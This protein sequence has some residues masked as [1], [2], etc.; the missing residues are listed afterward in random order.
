[1]FFL[2]R[3]TNLAESKQEVR[4]FPLVNGLWQGQAKALQKIAKYFVDEEQFSFRMNISNDLACAVTFFVFLL[5]GG[6]KKVYNLFRI[7]LFFHTLYYFSSSSSFFLYLFFSFFSLTF[8]FVVFFLQYYCIL[9][10]LFFSSANTFVPS[11]HLYFIDHL[12]KI[13]R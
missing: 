5:A 7:L 3:R 2:C 11:I 13:D 8:F 10:I 1:M 4:T 12:L 6:E 9:N